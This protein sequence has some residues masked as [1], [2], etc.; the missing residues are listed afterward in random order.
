MLILCH[1]IR[2]HVTVAIGG[3]GGDEVWCGY[4]WHRAFALADKALSVPFAL[5]SV[6]GAGAGRTC[7]PQWRY[8]TRVL[9]APDRLAA[10]AR[11]R[12]G[13]SDDMAKFLPVE[14][15][16]LPVAECFRESADRVGSVAEPLDW[17]SRM[18]LTTYLPDDLMVKADRTS[19]HVG[20]ELREPLLDHELSAFGLAAPISVRFDWRRRR[21]KVC[22]RRYLSQSLPDSLLERSKQGFTPPL[23]SWLNGPLFERKREALAR[24]KAAQLPTMALPHGL[25]CWDECSE[26]LDD[27]HHQFLWRIVC[28]SG[29]VTARAARI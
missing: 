18:D 19:M 27:I 17:A 26:K 11:L 6:L 4:P 28:F 2:K 3:D 13:L 1:E 5:R 8:K 14:V 21:G 16:P 22:P 23:D 29:W 15:P 24:L 7:G 20:L 9:A 10:W 25:K 12:T